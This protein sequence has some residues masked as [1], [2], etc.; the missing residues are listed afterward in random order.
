MR[1][2]NLRRTGDQMRSAAAFTMF[3]GVRLM[4]T[5]IGA[6]GDVI[7]ISDDEPMCM[8]TTTCSSLH[9][10]QNGIPVIRVD[11][12]PAE[13]GGVLREGHRMGALGRAAP[14]LGGQDLGVP[15]GR[16]R[17]RDEAARVGAAPLV[18]VPV[19]V[20]ADHG[21]GHV[22]VLGAGEE[23]PAELREGREAQRAEDAVGV[24]VVDPLVD[25]PA[26]GP[27][28]VERGG[29]HAVLFLRPT[30]HGVERDVAELGPL[31]E[32]R[33]RPVGP[34][35]ELRCQV[36]VLRREPALEHVG[37]LDQVVVHADQDQVIYIHQ[38]PPCRSADGLTP[39]S[40]LA[41][42]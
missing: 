24:H 19:V 29:L 1:S 27:D 20:G 14:Y 12:R 40:I 3:I 16:D 6:S 38:K 28:L 17:A 42:A 2:G 33:A 30:G 9:A 32:P 11:A 35:H 31:V 5:S 18:D 15:D 22:L 34:G 39:P 10:F 36:D 41:A 8:Q 37:R 25:V 21:Q 26:T 13:L 4:R 7:T 23:L